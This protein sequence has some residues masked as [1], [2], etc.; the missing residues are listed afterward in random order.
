[1][2][3]VKMNYGTD[4]KQQNKI[5]ICII[6]NHN[7]I[8]QTTETPQPSRIQNQIAVNRVGL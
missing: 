6:L 7:I 5:N 3:Q 4:W 1:M 2:Y 8:E